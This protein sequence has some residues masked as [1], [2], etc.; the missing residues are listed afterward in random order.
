[1]RTHIICILCVFVMLFIQCKSEHPSESKDFDQCAFTQ[2]D[3]S[4]SILSY[5]NH[6][7][8]LSRDTSGAFVL[9]DGDGSM[10]ARAWL[11]SHATKTID[12]QYFIFS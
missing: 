1:M 9:E 4:T 3:D 7:P 11:T 8:Q 5:L 6:V 2:K 10:I 12:I